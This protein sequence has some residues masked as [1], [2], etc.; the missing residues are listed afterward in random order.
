MDPS[1][2]P[3]PAI[4]L[5]RQEAQ[6]VERLQELAQAAVQP[7]VFAIAVLVI[8]AVVAVLLILGK[9]QPPPPVDSAELLVPLLPQPGLER[10][11][12]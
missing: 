2:A 4:G 6:D 5:S 9:A 8:T 12:R 11:E 1:P 3:E 10:P 7:W